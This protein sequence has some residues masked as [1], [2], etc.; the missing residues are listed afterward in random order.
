MLFSFHSRASG[1]YFS[2]ICWL[3]ERTKGWT[4]MIAKWSLVG[5]NRMERRKPLG[6][7]D[8]LTHHITS[9]GRTSAYIS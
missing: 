7:S 8:G 2:I 9:A 3:L 4:L 5:S 6:A 1:T